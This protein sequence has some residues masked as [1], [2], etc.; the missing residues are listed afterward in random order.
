MSGGGGKGYESLKSYISVADF[1]AR[2]IDL[3]PK[4]VREYYQ[5]GADDESTVARNKSAFRKYLIRPRVLVDVQNLDTKVTISFNPRESYTFEYPLGIAPT[6]F[7]RMA[8]PQGELATSMA[9]SQTNT[10]MICSTLSTTKLEDI[11]QAASVNANLWFQLYVYRDRRITENLVSRAIASGYRALVLTVDAP[12]MG[13]RRADERNG[14]ELPGHLKMENFDIELL[15]RTFKGKEGASGFGEYVKNMF[16]LTLNWDDLRWLVE[17]SKIPVIVKGIVRGCDAIKALEAGA[18]GIVVSNH[19]GRQIE[20]TVS[21]IEALPEVIEAVNGRCPVFVDGGI[22]SG[23]DIFKCIALGA[24]MVFIGR[25]IIY[26]L[27]VGGVE[28]VKHV[29]QIL[30]TEFEYA[31]RL[32]GISSIHQLRTVPRMVVHQNYYTFSKL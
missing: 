29:I 6:A 24:D 23:S 7:H 17:Y 32:S 14:F 27:S 16:D 15:A 12:M 21:T 20:S 5:S 19:G 1:E 30:R 26:G 8:H 28:G 3:L 18:R 13:R 10:L 2:A 9:A 22:R 4:A 11:A 31:M 25:P